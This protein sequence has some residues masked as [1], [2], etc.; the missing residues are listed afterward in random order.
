MA[1][2]DWLSWLTET[3]LATSVLI[4]LVLLLRRPVA[5]R[6]GAE[7]AYLLWLAPALRF[8]FPELAILPAPTGDVFAASAAAAAVDATAFAAAPDTGAS[9]TTNI[10]LALV[11]LWA[12]GAA[13]FA[14]GQF[15]A[16][17]AFRKR[18]LAASRPAPQ[19]LLAEATTVAWRRGYKQGFDL[20]VAADETGPLV[21]G[22]LRPLIVVP[23]SFA[24]R[25]SSHERQMALA[26]EFAHVARGDLYAALAAT[27]LRALQWFN[28]LAHVAWRTFRADQEAACDALVLRRSIDDP[29][30]RNV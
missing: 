14:L 6:F 10:S 2:A 1:A 21:T 16:Q 22:F 17:H 4:A 20:R 3:T 8:V 25:L 11:A 7:A 24:A 28:P 12:L 19:D 13:A 9:Q 30:A 26:H 18:L 15:G 29:K 23:A 5:R 27:L